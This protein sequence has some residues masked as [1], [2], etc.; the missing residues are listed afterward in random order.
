MTIRVKEQLGGESYL[1][2]VDG[3]GA[4]IV[5]KTD[6]EDDFSTGQGIHLALPEARVHRFD[7]AGQ[8]K[9]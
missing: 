7:A 5:V 6:G 3:D 1:Y 4:Q 2:T 9:R 8:A